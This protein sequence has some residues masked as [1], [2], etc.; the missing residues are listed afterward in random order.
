[1]LFVLEFACFTVS[2]E[3]NDEIN[4]MKVSNGQPMG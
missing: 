1:M 2:I 3:I 4:A